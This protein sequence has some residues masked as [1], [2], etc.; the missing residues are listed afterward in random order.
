ML[1]CDG[2]G[3]ELSNDR[4]RSAAALLLRIRPRIQPRIQI[5]VP[6][7]TEVCFKRRLQPE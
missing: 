5:A 4:R 6:G 3:N 7:T 2:T 1:L